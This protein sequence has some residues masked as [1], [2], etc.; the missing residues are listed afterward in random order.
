MT[1][2]AEKAKIE[3]EEFIRSLTSAKVNYLVT[4]TTL[5]LPPPM[6]FQEVRRGD[7]LPRVAGKGL[8][9]KIRCL[10]ELGA[11]WPAQRQGTGANRRASDFAQESG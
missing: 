6:C 9:G 11:F 4:Q 7:T 8:R 3:N 10:K 2:I 1:S 5:P